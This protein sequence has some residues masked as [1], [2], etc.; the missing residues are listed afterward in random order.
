MKKLGMKKV[1]AK[2]EPHFLTG[3]HTMER[4][5]WAKQ[6]LDMFEPQGPKQLTAVVTADETFISFY[7]MP[8]KQ[9]QIISC[10][11]MMPGTDQSYA[12]SD[13]DFRARSSSSLYLTTKLD[14]WWSTLC[15]RRHQ[16]PGA[17]IH[18]Q[19]QHC[20]KMLRLSMRSSD[21]T[22]ESQEHRYS[23]TMLLPTKQGPQFSIW[24]E[25]SY[26]SCPAQPVAPN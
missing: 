26:K 4:V 8:S 19:E 23:V 5:R 6:M 25:T 24:R 9:A 10:G 22:W 3:A 17:T 2:W 12:S 20:Q 16:W 1:C 14:P 13:L 11:S 21:Q 7:G 18:R 15:Q